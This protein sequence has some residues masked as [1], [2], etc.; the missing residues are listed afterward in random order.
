MNK[1]RRPSGEKTGEKSAASASGGVVKRSLS[2][3][4][5]TTEWPMMAKQSAALRVTPISLA[6]AVQLTLSLAPDGEG[7]VTAQREIVSA[8]ERTINA[9][10]QRIIISRSNVNWLKWTAL[11]LQAICTLTAI[12]MVHADNRGAAATAMGIFATGVAV[13]VLL[14]ASHDQPFSGSISVKP[15]LLE[16]VMPESP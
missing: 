1:R 12:A 15:D 9:R 3:F 11:L 4:S 8:L 14:I 10:R 6:E 16:Q 5:T 13:S 2:P 7:Q